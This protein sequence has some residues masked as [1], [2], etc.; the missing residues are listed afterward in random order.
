MKIYRAVYFAGISTVYYFLM[1][2]WQQRQQLEEMKK[3]ELVTTLREKETRNQLILTQNAFLRAQINPHFLINTLSYLYNIT[4]K[5]APKAAGSMLSLSEIMQYA[6]S[7]EIASGYVKLENEISLV[8][9]FLSLYQAQQNYKIQF[10]LYY[11]HKVQSILIIPLILMSIAELILKHGKLNDPDKPAEIKISY[12][13]SILCIKTANHEAVNSNI[14]NH[15]IDLKNV[16]NRLLTAY[17]EMATLD[18][19]LDSTGYFHTAITV[20]TYNY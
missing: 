18:Y 7:K 8:E 16:K 19:Y 20:Q 14:S 13:N 4:R 9:S 12:E 2:D 3:Q 5:S 6:L 10:K 11:D 1:R 17:G 15:N